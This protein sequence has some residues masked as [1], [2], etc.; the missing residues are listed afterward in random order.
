MVIWG[1]MIS[2]QGILENL[3]VWGVFLLTT[4]VALP[5]LQCGIRLGRRLHR[6]NREQEAQVRTIVGSA[7]GLMTFMLVFTFWIASSHYNEAR[8]AV[9]EEAGA[10]GTAY[11]N[12]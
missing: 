10:I 5:A 12:A 9:L 6:P 11:L 2:F 1:L 7:V 4:A 3:P 8:H